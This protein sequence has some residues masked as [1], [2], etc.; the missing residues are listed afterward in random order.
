MM[1]IKPPGP[2]SGPSPPGK[3]PDGDE[4]IKKLKKSLNNTLILV[5]GM[6]L[7]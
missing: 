7:R 1:G 4:V 3:L 5:T 2:P 6:G